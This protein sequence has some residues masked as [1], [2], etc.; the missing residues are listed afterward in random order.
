MMLGEDAKPSETAPLSNENNIFRR[1][2]MVDVYTFYVATATRLSL[3]TVP[4][5]RFCRS[6]VRNNIIIIYIYR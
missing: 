3:S 6:R 5:K 2:I 1:D 4:S